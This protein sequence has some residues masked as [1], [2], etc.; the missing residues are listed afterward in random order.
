LSYQLDRV[1]QCDENGEQLP[2]KEVR[3]GGKEAA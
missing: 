3:R 1:F 2:N